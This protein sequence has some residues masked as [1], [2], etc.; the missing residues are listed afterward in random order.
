MSRHTRRLVLAFAASLVLAVAQGRPFGSPDRMLAQDRRPITEKDLFKFVWIADPQMAPDGSQIA[1]VRV[2]VDEKKDQY[3]NGIWIAKADGSEPPRQ[4]T[5][6]IRDSAPRWSPD[7]H[8][9][10]FVRSPEKDG[11]PQP[12]QIYVLS[13]AG[14]EGRAITDIPRGAGNPAWSPDGSEIAIAKWHVKNR[15]DNKVVILDAGTGIEKTR[16]VG[17]EKWI[18]SVAYSF[19]GEK[20]VTASSDRTARVWSAKTGKEFLK[21]EGHTFSVRSAAFSPHGKWII[22]GSE[23]GTFRIWSA[24]TGK[25][26]FRRQ[27]QKGSEIHAVSFLLDSKR[28]ITGGFSGMAEIWASR[29]SSARRRWS[30]AWRSSAR[31]RAS[32]AA[33]TSRR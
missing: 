30:R 5:T 2:T 16:L 20:I 7:S 26:V 27:A 13:M 33:P 3:E 28:V 4:L 15:D 19:D 29:S 22:T 21:L 23:D 18:S 11:K 25:S 14:G 31:R 1:F 24:R 9:L 8:R 6:G 10:A 12:S 17:H 32:G